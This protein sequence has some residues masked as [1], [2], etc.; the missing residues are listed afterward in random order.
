[1]SLLS[2]E[3]VE[4]SFALPTGERRAVIDVPTF[5]VDAA[6]QVALVGRSGSGKST[7]L[8]LI[9][10]LLVPDAGRVMIDGTDLAALTEARRDRCRGELIGYLFQT[11]NLIQGLSARE[12]VLVGMSFGGHR[13]S[14]F[15]DEL[16]ARLGLGDR[17]DDKPARLSVGQ[18]QRVALARALAHRPKLVLAD[19]PTSSLDPDHGADALRLLREH[20]KEEGAALI[21]VTHSPTVS[22]QF[23]DVRELAS[24]NRAA[25][26]AV[27]A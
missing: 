8:H 7:L 23:A 25:R 12:N 24:F 13:D 22:A 18:Q 10:G 27:E 5:A 19:E 15:A 21:L 9:A 6:A 4:K 17:L 26:V 3:G 14:T 2:L 20:C 1:M 16:L 11:F